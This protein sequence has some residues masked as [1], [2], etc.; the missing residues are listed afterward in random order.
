MMAVTVQTAACRPER[1]DRPARP[2]ANAGAKK[3]ATGVSGSTSASASTSGGGIWV[4]SMRI[5]SRNQ[6]ANTTAAAAAR[7][8]A[9]RLAPSHRGDATATPRQPASTA[10]R[11]TAAGGGRYSAA[12]GSRRRKITVT[13][14]DAA[15]PPVTK[16]AGAGTGSRGRPERAT[17]STT[18]APARPVKHAANTRSPGTAAPTTGPAA[19]V[20]A[21]ATAA[22]SASTVQPPAGGSHSVAQT[23]LSANRHRA[24]RPPTSASSAVIALPHS[25]RRSG[26]AAT[27][28]AS[29]RPGRSI[30]D[31]RAPAAD[32]QWRSTS[33]AATTHSSG[34]TM[35]YITAVSSVGSGS[36][37]ARTMT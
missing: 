31:M 2:A 6:A 10:A 24:G 36:A 34:G 14:I 5:T 27:A 21:T 15:T 8:G 18:I 26:S 25:R 28:A 19:V 37:V 22:T 33:R 29:N 11:Y 16:T 17:A 1:N 7:W 30:A 13:A 4:P 32:H 3:T 9:S 12:A 20:A 23:L 35:R